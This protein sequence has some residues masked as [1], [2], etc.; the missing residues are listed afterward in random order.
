MAKFV[1]AQ[2]DDFAED[3]L[4]VRQKVI[5]GGFQTE[6]GPDGFEYTNI[7]L[8]P[9]V[10]KWYAK[11]EQCLGRAILPK[12][13]VF[14]QNMSGEMPHS[15]VHSD[16]ICASYAS[17]LYLNLPDQCRGG[18]VFWQH[19]Q[20]G[21][22]YMPTDE[23][24]ANQGIDP[25]EFGK[26]MTAAWKDKDQWAPNSFVN[27]KSNRFITYPCS[28]IHSRWPWEGWGSTHEDARFV[29]ALFYD[30]DE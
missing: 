17:V 7:S 25:V 13:S 14:R 30:F 11:I 23:Q 21:L 24:L 26:N 18:T 28:R 16:D 8:Y 6:T 4:E 3:F 12:L 19:K 22:E 2:F 10:A 1:L 27:M 5:D 29:W 20:T 9:Y 15:F